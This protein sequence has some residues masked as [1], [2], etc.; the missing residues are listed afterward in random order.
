MHWNAGQ[1]LP[2][3]QQTD[4]TRRSARSVKQVFARHD[5]TFLK[6][7]LKMHAVPKHL[8]PAK[9]ASTVRGRSAQED[10]WWVRWGLIT[11][12]VLALLILVILPISNVFYHAF[13]SGIGTYVKNLTDRETMHA[14]KL[15]M[16]VAPIAVLANVVFGVAAAWAITR[17]RFPGRTLLTTIIDLPFAISPVVVGLMFVM[18]FGNQGVFGTWLQQNGFKILFAWPGIVLATT[19]VTLPFVARELIPVMEAIGSDEEIAAISLGANGWQMFWRVS[20]P[21]MKWGLLYGIILCNARAMGE[22]GA[23]YVVSGRIINKTETLPIRVNTLFE[24]GSAETYTA[25]FAA[26]SLLT[27]LALVTLFIKIALERKTQLDLR[28]AAQI[29][30]IE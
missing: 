23:V 18:L 6:D 26:A 14:I 29:Q 15:T 21:N 10:P 16:F 19:F 8:P 7:G 13:S 24:G 25:S 17:F 9:A 2:I 3:H 28:E 1:R 4:L 27:M 22:F 20:L 12:S 5:N 11:I 30:Q